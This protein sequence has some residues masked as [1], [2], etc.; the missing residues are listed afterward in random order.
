MNECKSRNDISNLIVFRTF[1]N[2]VECDFE[3]L[4][5]WRRVNV[6][7]ENMIVID[8]AWDSQADVLITLHKSNTKK[9]QKSS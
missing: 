6:E 7:Y 8:F 9:L 3:Y 4:V 5:E 1:C 2:L